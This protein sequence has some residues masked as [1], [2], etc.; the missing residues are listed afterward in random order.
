MPASRVSPYRTE[1][2]VWRWISCCGVFRKAYRS[3]RHNP[4]LR[5]VPMKFSETGTTDAST[6]LHTAVTCGGEREKR[7]L[8]LPG[9]CTICAVR[10]KP[11]FRSFCSEVLSIY[12]G[13]TRPAR[14]AL[15]QAEG[16][17]AG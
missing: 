6:Y 16:R 11:G 2:T 10:R 13:T 17:D 3:C 5:R 4:P 15:P 7:L 14:L 9:N 12:W 1:C 8:P